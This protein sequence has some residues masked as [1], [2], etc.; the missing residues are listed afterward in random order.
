MTRMHKIFLAGIFISVCLATVAFSADDDFF[1][2]QEINLT[3]EILGCRY[4]DFNGDSM[5]D[6]A[7][8]VTEAG[9]ERTLNSYIQRESG[10]FPPT[11]SQRV[12]LAPTADMVQAADINNDGKMDILTV[13]HEGVFLYQSSGDGFPDRPRQVIAEPTI[14][15]GSS[16][17]E[18]MSQKFLYAI[19]G[20]LTAFVP[21][22]DGY[23]L[24]EYD[25]G[26]FSQVSKLGFSHLF[27]ADEAP[28]KLFTAR[29]TVYEMTLPDIVISDFNR[30][31]LADIYLLWPTHLAIFPQ[32]QKGKFDTGPKIS[33]DF[34]K[35]GRD[36]LCQAVLVDFDRDGLLDLV[37]SHSLGG[38]SEART[39]FRFFGA[40]QITANDRL[41][42]QLITLTDVCGNLMVRDFDGVGG[43]ELVVP[44]IELGIL[45]T[46]KNMIAKKTDF[47]FLVYPID[48][49][50]RPSKEPKIRRKVT[51]RLNFE[52]TDP[53]GDFRLDWSG[54][55]NKDGILDLVTA[56]G[57]QMF[58]YSGVADEYIEK[59]AG[60][61]LNIAHVDKIITAQLNNDGNS[62]LILIHKPGGGAQKVTLLVTNR[63]Y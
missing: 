29:S 28:I 5:T 39:E 60:L 19:N 61:V 11:I 47:H 8:I 38:L 23:M 6:I 53:T 3:G 2:E 18:I 26:Q 16:A 40:S 46:V 17:G 9:G 63:I 57:E 50:G 13:T 55:Y 48:N 33:F 20:R 54:D 32:G 14:F 45:T 7:V 56:D 59:K 31:D 30:D 25:N 21:V 22:V 1:Q 10:R 12:V 49:L 52:Q 62:D 43:P 44:A 36:N 58:F 24:Y 27:V 42:R 41:E 15:V 37:C 35:Y 4:G 34:G 51:C